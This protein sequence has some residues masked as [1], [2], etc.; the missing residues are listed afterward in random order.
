MASSLPTTSPLRNP[1]G[2]SQGQDNIWRESQQKR[3]QNLNHFF[4]DLL[5]FSLSFF[6]FSN[7]HG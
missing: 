2:R 1:E 4:D 3:M 6:P 7:G 5:R